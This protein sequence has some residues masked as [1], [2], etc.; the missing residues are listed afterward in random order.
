MSS[1]H[2][3]THNHLQ[4]SVLCTSTCLMFSAC[5]LR[6]YKKNIRSYKPV[7]AIWSILRESWTKLSSWTKLASSLQISNIHHCC[8]DVTLSM[9]TSCGSRAHL[10]Q[11][12]VQYM[13]QSILNTRPDMALPSV[14]HVSLS[15]L[16]RCICATRLLMLI[17]RQH[18]LK[19]SATVSSSTMVSSAE[20]S[21]TDPEF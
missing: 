12:T 5:C 21:Q 16:A 8:G 18:T 13:E 3:L 6:D 20:V 4:V 1:T 14:L 17:Y 15:R 10:S 7:T 11:L 9:F 19:N 2:L